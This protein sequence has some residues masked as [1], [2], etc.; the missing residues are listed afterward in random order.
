MEPQN[1]FL[2]NALF[3]QAIDFSHGRHVIPGATTVLG[4]TTSSAEPHTHTHQVGKPSNPIVIEEEEDQIHYPL[5]ISPSPTPRDFTSPRGFT[6]PQALVIDFSAPETAIPTSVLGDIARATTIDPR[7]VQQQDNQHVHLHRQQPGI[8]KEPD[9]HIVE[10]DVLVQSTT[11]INNVP[12]PSGNDQVSHSQMDSNVAGVVLPDS[13]V[14]QKNVPS[15][16]TPDQPVHSTQSDVG[17]ATPTTSLDN[18]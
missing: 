6:S 1:R 17:P 12:T 15:A 16:G 4:L 11:D 10:Q 18:R 14:S 3:L 13:I 9:N 2:I 8:L 5:E 7:L